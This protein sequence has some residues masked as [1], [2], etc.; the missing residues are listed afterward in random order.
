MFGDKF[1]SVHRFANSEI[2]SLSVPWLG[3]MDQSKVTHTLEVLNTL[4]ASQIFKAMKTNY[5]YTKQ[6]QLLRRDLCSE[7][8]FFH[9]FVRKKLINQQKYL[10]DGNIVLKNKQFSDK[11]GSEHGEYLLMLSHWYI[12]ICTLTP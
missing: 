10:I 11:S 6:V 8:Q 5:A 1:T 2:Y 3:Q 12:V 7:L 9:E 4:L